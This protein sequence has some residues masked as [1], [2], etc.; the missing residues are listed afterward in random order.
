MFVQRVI[1]CQMP[2]V[3]GTVKQFAIAVN[4]QFPGGALFM[5]I[6]DHE[7]RKLMMDMTSRMMESYSDHQRHAAR[8]IGRN[9]I[10]Q[11]VYWIMSEAVQITNDGNIIEDESPFLWVRRLVN[12][13]NILLQETLAC[14]VA[15]PL[16]SGEKFSHSCQKILCLLWQ[17][18]QPALWV[19]VTRPKY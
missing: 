12:G 18:W 7:F 14:K 6:S 16:D 8:L 9:S 13:T 3:S 2:E 11:S 1:F 19:R 4:Q 10:E 15:T 5:L 17:Q